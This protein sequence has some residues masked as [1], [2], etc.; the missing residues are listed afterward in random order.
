MI[1]ME[2]KTI[3]IPVDGSEPAE[4]AFRYG[5]GLAEEMKPLSF[6]STSWMPMKHTMQQ[7]V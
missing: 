5:V 4:N 6:F 2:I 7:T 3:L 1:I